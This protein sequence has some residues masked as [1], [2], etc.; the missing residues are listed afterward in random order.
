MLVVMVIIASITCKAQLLK[1]GSI[2]M[3][4]SPFHTDCSGSTTPSSLSSS[5][6]AIFD[7][8]NTSAIPST[9]SNKFVWTQFTT[10]NNKPLWVSKADWIADSIGKVF[11]ITLDDIGNIYVANTSI[12]GGETTTQHD[13]IYKLDRITGN[14]S[15]VFDYADVN[16]TNSP[17]QG[18]GNLKLFKIG[19]V[20]YIAFTCWENKKIFILKEPSGGLTSTA[21]WTIHDASKPTLLNATSVPYGVAVRPKPAPAVGIYEVYYGVY[22]MASTTGHHTDINKIEIDNM[23]HF[24]ASSETNIFTGITSTSIYCNNGTGTV[25][26]NTPIPIADIS[27]SSDFKKMVVGEQGLTNSYTYQAHN[28]IVHEYEFGTSWTSTTAKL[29]C[30]NTYDQGAPCPINGLNAVGGVSYW[31]NI[32]F[33][34]AQTKCDTTILYST[35]LIYLS[36][37]YSAYSYSP[38]P[39]LGHYAALTNEINT[40]NNNFGLSQSQATVSVYGF[41]GLASKNSTFATN[42]DAFNGSLKVDADDIFNVCDKWRLGDIEAFNVPISCLP[43]CNCGTWQNIQYGS[44]TNWWVSPDTVTTISF[45]QGQIPSNPIIPKYNCSSNCNATFTYSLSST[46]GIQITLTSNISGG[47]VLSS[48]A[49]A[50]NNLPCGNYSLFITPKCG[51]NNCPPVRIPIVITCPPICSSCSGNAQISTQTQPSI[52]YG[53]V[54]MSYT[55]SNS[56]PVTEVRASVEEFRVINSSGNEN[57]LLCQNKPKTWGS[58]QSASLAGVTSTTTLS[59]DAAIDNREVVF[60]NTPLFNLAGNVLSMNLAIPQ[61]TGLSCCTLKAEVCIKFIIRDINCCEKEIIKCFTFDLK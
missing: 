50:I 19:S 36:T 55:L 57:C 9:S 31:N 52:S 44:N 20:N 45:L 7:A 54:T 43:P 40:P 48:N 3:T 28:S 1:Q 53:T 12:Y 60:K 42:L 13:K 2:V 26:N 56:I 33:S 37:A 21:K 34:D 8:S 11:G 30:G 24:I 17:N 6:V 39:R 22:D 10:G 14:K 15:V 18:L 51:S 23:G 46:N 5:V 35:D 41:Q 61:T 25:N 49:Q 59:T 38:L 29:P 58:I 16:A 4:H 32:L 47:V 27:F